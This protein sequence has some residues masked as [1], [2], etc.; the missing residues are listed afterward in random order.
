MP[1]AARSRSAF[2]VTIAGFLPPIS[3][4]SGRSGGRACSVRGDRVPGLGRA[5]EGDAVGGRRDQRAAD[6]VVAV[7]DV[8]DARREPSLGRQLGEQV[9]S[10][11]GSPRP[12]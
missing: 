12:A 8:E 5:G 3:A 7:D 4:I 11:T 9:P 2:A 1:S 6:R 10:T